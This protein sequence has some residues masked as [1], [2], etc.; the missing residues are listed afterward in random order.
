MTGKDKS[1]IFGEYPRIKLLLLTIAVLVISGLALGRMIDLGT[2]EAT[3]VAAGVS[4]PGRDLS[5]VEREEGIALLHDMGEVM[6]DWTVYF[7]LDDHSWQTT[8]GELGFSLDAELTMDRAL[9]VREQLNA[10]ERLQSRFY[11]V[12]RQVNLDVNFDDRVL[13]N[14]LTGITAGITSEPVDA[15]FI[16]HKD[17]TVEVTPGQP[18]RKLVVSQVKE[19]LILNLSQGHVP[20]VKL[21]LEVIPPK[22]TESQVRGL[23]LEGLVAMASTTFKEPGGPRADNIRNAASRLDGVLLAPGQVLSFNETVGP[24]TA[25]RGYRIAPVII[26][27]KFDEGMGG[28]VCQV[29]STAYKAALLAGLAVVERHNHS[30]AVSYIDLGLDAAVVYGMLDLK[31]R[32]D[33]AAHVLL[34]TNVEG[35]LMTVKIFGTVKP[36][37][38]ISLASAVIEVMEPE[39]LRVADPELPAGVEEVTEKGA[40][41]Y[42]VTTK[43]IVA[44]GDAEVITEQLP[45]SLYRP[46]N[47]VIAVGE[48]LAG[49]PS[50]NSSQGEEE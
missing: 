19:Q 22:V 50:D 18:G 7:R 13:N 33:S 14:Y 41:G 37:R 8:T 4:V 31:L 48:M 35:S 10:L 45:G 49:E 15:T 29:S 47:R 28:G 20:E 42:K 21:E 46:L 26:G 36:D 38:K 6:K 11:P 32:N 39:E 34:K 9:A 5:N 40:R 27:N 23:G 17:D 25:E 16:I 1:G 12:N 43:R 3:R 24:R 44:V 30:L 2:A